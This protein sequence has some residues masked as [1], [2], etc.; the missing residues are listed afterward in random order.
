M[1]LKEK[2]GSLALIA[3]ASEGIGAAY[4]HHL[5]AAGIDLV[6]IARRKEPL[7]RFAVELNS[8]YGIKTYCIQEDLSSPDAASRII[9]QVRTYEINLLIY[10]AGNSYIDKFEEKAWN[11]HQ[12]IVNTNM[13]TPLH[14][15]HGIAPEMLKRGK[16]AIILMASLAGFQGTPYIATYA[17]TK[18]FDQVLAESLWYEWKNRGID[19]IACCAGAT[20]SPNFISTNPGKQN[21]FAPKVQTPEEVVSECFKRLGKT[22]SFITGSGNKIASFFMQRVLSRKKAVTIMGDT[23]KKMY[24]M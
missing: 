4:A 23:T 18:A 12:E 1:T 5:A 24:R 11:I 8:R 20:S 14:L 3:G 2:Y 6:L 22:P 16:G 21:F 7:D 15:I 17:A 19:V 13:I 10:N 9:D